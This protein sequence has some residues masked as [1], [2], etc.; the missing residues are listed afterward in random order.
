[1]VDS[2]MASEQM[3]DVEYTW[4]F[5]NQ[6]DSNPL[7]KLGFNPSNIYYQRTGDATIGS[8]LDKDVDRELWGKE[9]GGYYY[10]TPGTYYSN[11]STESLKKRAEE[12]KTKLGKS[13]RKEVF[14]A[15]KAGEFP[16][17]DFLWMAHY[18]AIDDK[19]SLGSHIHEFVHRTFKQNKEFISFW[20]KNRLGF[21][22][23]DHGLIAYMIG[24][25][26]PELK[27]SE[28]E[29]ANSEYRFNIDDKETEEE[30]K[31]LYEEATKIAEETLVKRYNNMM[32]PILAR[33][34]A[35][36]HAEGYQRRIPDPK[37]Q[38]KEKLSLIDR[39]KQ[40]FTGG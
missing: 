9:K 29:R 5:A 24:K 20:N 23:R 38:P 17:D 6:L 27:D 1:M 18:K 7:F 33:K 28:Y 22:D 2:L 13:I 10:K 36:K 19:K 34:S 37:E 11:W 21:D 26:F 15:A 16:A 31:N 14:E 4:K 3:G 35:A 8:Y 40:L 32:A 30:F 39:I 25:Q 12:A